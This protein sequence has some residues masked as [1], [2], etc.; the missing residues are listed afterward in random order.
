MPAPFANYLA[1]QMGP[2]LISGDEE[3]GAFQMFRRGGGAGGGMGRGRR[4]G[5]DADPQMRQARRT[6]ARYWRQHNL[7]G[8]EDLGWDPNL[9]GDE[10]LGADDEIGDEDLGADD[11]EIAALEGDDD[12][13][14]ADGN[15]A[16]GATI[17]QIDHRLGRLRTKLATLQARYDGTPP[18]RWRRRKHLLARIERVRTLIAKKEAKRQAKIAV[19]AAKM[20]VPA[21]ALLAGGAAGAA[22]GMQAQQLR[23]AQADAAFNYN[24][25]VPRQT[26]AGEEQRVSFQDT[27]TGSQVVTIAVAAGA[28]LRTAAIAMITPLISFAKFRVTGLDVKFQSIQGQ[29]AANTAL[30][31]EMLINVLLTNVTVNG[32][33]NLL[34][35][36]LDVCFGAQT[37]GNQLSA[38]RTVPG[39]RGNPILD[40]N[41]TAS[42]TAT[43][44]QELTT[45]VAITATFEAAL[46]TEV[47]EDAQA[48][49]GSLAA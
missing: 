35:T 25:T 19:L 44:R 14:G 26:P 39:L 2:P 17:N 21:A 29:A 10:D 33:I 34:Y 5:G 43:F 23:Q 48:R 40:K 6:L 11:D 24:G 27:T 28:G 15:E 49:A 30:A 7:M 37:V 9:M 18:H 47:L 22:V 20:G 45:T 31:S 3:L 13:I 16:V 8:D 41:N 4:G 46:I 42:L 1:R 32:G 36:T 38:R 12:A